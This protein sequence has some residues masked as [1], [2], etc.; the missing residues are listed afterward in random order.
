[1]FKKI[2]FTVVFCAGLMFQPANAANV[3]ITMGQA[4]FL[5][6]YKVNGSNG[7]FQDTFDYYNLGLSTQRGDY[8]FGVNV[9]GLLETTVQEYYENV[10]DGTPDAERNSISVFIGKSISDKLSLSGGYYTSEVTV[11]D[12]NYVGPDDTIETQALFASLTFSDQLTDQLFYYSRL[13]AQINEAEL[14]VHPDE[15]P[16]VNQTLDGVAWLFGTGIVYPLNDS[17]NVTFGFEYKDFI[18]DGGAWDLN[19]DQTLFTIGYSY[20]FYSVR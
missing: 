20:D 5:L 6:D 16:V 10:P 4:D 18:Y 12:T 1:M 15:E 8:T 14:T 3:S 17:T 2:H 11:S 7:S 9:S 19:E 13:G